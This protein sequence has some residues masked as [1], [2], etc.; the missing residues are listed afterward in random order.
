MGAQLVMALVVEAPDGGL[1]ER[2]VHA[3]DLTV[4]PGVVWPGEPM[5]D[6]GACAG[7]LEGVGTEDL[8]GLE[9][10]NDL[11]NRGATRAGIGEVRAVVGEDGVDAVGHRCDQAPEEIGSDATGR[12]LSSS[13]KANLLVRSMATNRR[14]L[15]SAVRTSAMSM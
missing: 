12:L 4:S 13:A 7:Q 8:A 10:S 6:A 1:L 9:R 5:L 3:L 14:S 15:P 2:P 11:R